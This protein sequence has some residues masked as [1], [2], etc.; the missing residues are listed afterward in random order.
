[1]AHKHYITTVHLA[2]NIF[3][4]FVFNLRV[5][6]GALTDF[7]LSVQATQPSLKKHNSDLLTMM[8]LLPGFPLPGF[9]LYK[10]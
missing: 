3:I 5:F 1:M 7:K 4:Q 2:C 8:L 6:Q 10:I 9:Q